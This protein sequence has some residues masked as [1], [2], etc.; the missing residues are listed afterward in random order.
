MAQRSAETYTSR[1]PVLLVHRQIK[2]QC[3]KHAHL[4]IVT[5]P[6][7]RHASRFEPA[8]RI[9]LIVPARLPLMELLRLTLQRTQTGDQRLKDLNIELAAASLRVVEQALA[10]GLQVRGVV[11]DAQGHDR[12]LA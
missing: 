8:R 12:F 1:S 6:L 5:N 9:H 7:H 3:L 10:F 4:R 2:Q 11:S